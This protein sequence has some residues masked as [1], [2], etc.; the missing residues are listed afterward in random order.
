MVLRDV[1]C[2]CSGGV[3]KEEG[4]MNEHRFKI[5]CILFQVGT[6]STNIVL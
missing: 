2:L 3:G 5:T 1:M 4:G 6:S